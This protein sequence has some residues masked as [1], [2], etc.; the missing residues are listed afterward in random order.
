MTALLSRLFPEA[1]PEWRPLP[2]TL[3]G[4]APIPHATAT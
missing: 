1:F 4:V 2:V 3:S